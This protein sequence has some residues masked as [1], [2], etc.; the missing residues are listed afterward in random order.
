MKWIEF[1]EIPGAT[2]ATTGIELIPEVFKTTILI[3]PP[4]SNIFKNAIETDGKQD[5]NNIDK[6]NKEITQL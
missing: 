3:F 6:N 4:D 5:S 2:I 1:E